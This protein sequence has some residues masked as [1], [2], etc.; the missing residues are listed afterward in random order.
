MSRKH[1]SRAGLDPSTAGGHLPPAR[2]ALTLRLVLASFG[3]VSS[4]LGLAIVL[5]LGLPWG[6]V[7]LFAL[8]ALTAAVDLFVVTRRRR[9]E[10]ALP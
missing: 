5:L 10:R 9:R 3:L 7:L 8:I 6:L 4:L 2:S 1:L